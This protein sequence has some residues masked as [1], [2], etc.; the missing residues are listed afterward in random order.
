[1][2]IDEQEVDTELASQIADNVQAEAAEPEPKEEAPKNETLEETL[3]RS[4]DELEKKAQEKEGK[5]DVRNQDTSKKGRNFS[6]KARSQAQTPEDTE[7]QE[8]E[9]LK[10]PAG[11]KVERKEWFL[12][13]PR[14]VQEEVLRQT[15]E[16]DRFFYQRAEEIKRY[17]KEQQQKWGG[18]EQAIIPY[19][20][21]WGHRGLTP[22]E[23]IV[24]LASTH[25]YIT[26]NPVEGIRQLM[27][28]MGVT[29]EQLAG[30]HGGY[31]QQSAA[32]PPQFQQQFVAMQQRLAQLEGVHQSQIQQTQQGQSQEIA[33]AISRVRD[34][35]DPATGKYLRPELH[36]MGFLE[37]IGQL[38][39]H[40]RAANPGMSWEDAVIAAHA[41]ETGAP[42][43]SATSALSNRADPSVV[44]RARKANVSL[45]GGSV[46]NGASPAPKTFDN[47]EDAARAAVEELYG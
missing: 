5:E 11:W 19:L 21:K 10:P 8:L 24:R 38:V 42:P 15:Q 45:R 41:F 39:T 27:Q 46:V 4:Y 30:H 18:I 37:R 29:V 22:Q 26:Q 3:R 28:G 2:T 13:Q 6:K 43:A 12:K 20:H 23:A 36:D 35:R 32:I 1:M 16:A 14:E 40:K 31:E 9:E 7:T 17:E 25:D 47:W 34:Q 44:A 33:Q